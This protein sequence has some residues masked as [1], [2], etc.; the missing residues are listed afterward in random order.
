M[1]TQFNQHCLPKDA[2]GAYA[3]L[4]FICVLDPRHDKVRKEVL[5]FGVCVGCG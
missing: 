4:E 5:F 1:C 3:A 2:T